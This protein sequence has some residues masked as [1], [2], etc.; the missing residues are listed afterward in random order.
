KRTETGDV[1][2]L[3]FEPPYRLWRRFSTTPED[4]KGGECRFR[5]ECCSLKAR[6]AA[7]EANVVVCNYH[8]LFAHLQVKA[9]TDQDLVLPPFDVAILDEAHKASDIARDFFGYRVTAGAVR[10]AGRL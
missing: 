3:P 8:L 9:A 6:A 4:C 1:S 5:E 7:H 2:E 10:L